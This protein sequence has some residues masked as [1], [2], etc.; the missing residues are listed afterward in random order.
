MARLAP[1][2]RSHPTNGSCPHPDAHAPLDQLSRSVISIE[3]DTCSERDWLFVEN[4]KAVLFVVSN[5]E[6]DGI[7]R[8]VEFNN[9]FAE[10]FGVRPSHDDA[11]TEHCLPLGFATRLANALYHCLKTSQTIGFSAT[12]SKRPNDHHWEFLLEPAHGFGPH[13]RHILVQ[14]HDVTAQRQTVRDLKC[15]TRKLLSAQEDERRRIARDLHDSTAQ[16]LVVLGIGIT[17][18]EILAKQQDGLNGYAGQRLVAD[19]RV[20]L[21]HAHDE[22]RTLSLLL[23]PPELDGTQIADTLRRFVAGFAR[24]TGIQARFAVD[25]NLFC[26]SADAA[27]ALMRIA[28]EALANVYRHADATEVTVELRSES[29]LLMLRIEDNGKG[30]ASDPATNAGDD[31]EM[32][33]VGILGMRARVRQLDGDLFIKNGNRGAL[34][35]ATIPQH[36]AWPDDNRL[37]DGVATTAG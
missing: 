18:L 35:I 23:H 29:R 27:T 37:N 28:Q 19:M 6:A 15:V 33:G 5:D 10:I 1:A 22:I 36:R 21:S 30:F 4:S 20:A 31:T 7:W 11:N 13:R 25:K 2:A 8:V 32:I 24:R 26:A 14:G 12:L 3:Q 16:H 9:A 34:I 17:H